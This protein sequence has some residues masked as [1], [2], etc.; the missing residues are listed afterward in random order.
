MSLLSIDVDRFKRINDEHDHPGGDAVLQGLG[1]VLRSVV[2]DSDL[3]ARAGG[4]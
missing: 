1:Q 4:G 3:A 2:R